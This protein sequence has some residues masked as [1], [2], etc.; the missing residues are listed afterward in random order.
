LPPITPLQAIRRAVKHLSAQPP[1]SSQSPAVQLQPTSNPAQNQPDTIVRTP[2]RAQSRKTNA[3]ERCSRGL[4]MKKSI[5]FAGLIQVA[6]ALVLAAPAVAQQQQFTVN[7]PFNFDVEG[8]SFANG[9]YRVEVISPVLVEI[10]R[11]DNSASATFNTFRQYRPG[12]AHEDAQ[13]V[14]HRY[15]RRY[16]LAEAWFGGSQSGHILSLSHAEK[17]Y[18]KQ[19]P[20]TNT[21]L[22]AAK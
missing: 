12:G 2:S 9:K 11:T 5:G 10:R 1:L 6:V 17:E 3:R 20:K 16:F 8:Q 4:D 18:A 19:A 13:L 7:V 14:F 15:N 21:F 22:F